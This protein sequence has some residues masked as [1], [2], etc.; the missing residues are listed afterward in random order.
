MCQNN[1]NLILFSRTNSI[2]LT[3][4]FWKRFFL[5][6]PLIPSHFLCHPPKSR[7]LNMQ[8]VFSW[9]LCP[10]S[11]ARSFATGLVAALVDFHFE[12][13]LSYPQAPGSLLLP[14]ISCVFKKKLFLPEFPPIRFCP[15]ELA[16][17][18]SLSSFRSPSSHP[19]IFLFLIQ[20]GEWDPPKPLALCAPKPAAALHSPSLVVGTRGADVPWLHCS[21]SSCS[22]SPSF[23]VAGRLLDNFQIC[24]AP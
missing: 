15:L 17:S 21:A 4:S 3:T 20:Q 11:H 6:A 2:Q 23:R 19:D 13:Q 9:Y 1:F 5:L 14:L 16:L 10:C 12:F 7:H 18:P 8:F 22:F 24:K